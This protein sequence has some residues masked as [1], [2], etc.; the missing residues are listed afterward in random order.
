MG[1]FSLLLGTFLRSVI[2]KFSY[3]KSSDV[4]IAGAQRK[5][6]RIFILII[7]DQTPK[8]LSELSLHSGQG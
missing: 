5:K 3:L 7:I 8:H 1:N 6:E 2:M 4:Q